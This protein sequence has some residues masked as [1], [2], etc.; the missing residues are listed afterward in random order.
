MTRHHFPFFSLVDLSFLAARFCFKGGRKEPPPSHLRYIVGSSQVQSE[1][2][3][4]RGNETLS[5]LLVTCAH[6]EGPPLRPDRDRIFLQLSVD[7]SQNLKAG[8][9]A[10]RSRRR[11]AP[12]LRQR[13]EVVGALYHFVWNEEIHPSVRP[14]ILTAFRDLLLLCPSL[15]PSCDPWKNGVLVT[16]DFLKSLFNQLR[17]PPPSLR[18][19]TESRIV[20]TRRCG[21]VGEPT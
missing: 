5:T 8:R 15:V 14:S 21:P 9:K 17:L 3:G 10:L 18:I 1:R 6:E 11:L 7:S 12:P 16:R 13:L 2:R 20:L 4:F 19:P